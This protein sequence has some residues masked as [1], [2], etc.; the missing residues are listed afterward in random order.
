MTVSDTGF[1]GAPDAVARRHGLASLSTYDAAGVSLSTRRGARRRAAARP[2]SSRPA[3][4]GFGAFAGLHPLDDRR[5]L[6]ASTDSVG[7]KLMLARARGP[8]ARLR[9][10]PG[11]ALHQRRD[12][13]R[14]RAALPARLRRREADR[15]SSR[16]RELVEGAAEVCRAAGCALIGGETAE[17]PGIYRDDELD[18]AGT[19]VGIVERDGLVDG[20]RVEAGDV[21][22][23]F[24]SAGVHAN[25]FTLVR[26]VLEDEDYDGDRPARADA[27][28]PRRRARAA[29]TTAHALAHVTGGGIAGNLARV[30]PDGLRA[31]LDWDAWERPPVFEWLARA[32]RGGRAAP[33]L[34]PRDRLRAPSSPTRAARHRDRA[35]RRVIGV[36]VSGEGTN[37]Q[38]LIDAACRSRPSRRTAPA[39]GRSSAR[40]AAGIPTA[41]FALDDY[42]SREERD[43]AMA[44][45]LEAARRRARRVRGLHAPAHA[46]FLDRFPGRIVNIHPSLLPAF[47]GT[48]P[49]EDALAAGVPETGVTVHYVDEGVDTG[50]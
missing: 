40:A 39:R 9:R 5:L 33:R 26:R 11:R 48:R 8:P 44:D 36:L 47:P 25:G 3:R 34:Q 41:V 32:R 38:A 2:R 23:G 31:E 43:A 37:L 50:P 10:R 16:S 19:C 49:I 4:P 24:P 7:T 15:R 27:A 30:V 17:L 45:W 20:S 6:A 1:D 22:V 28:L 21:V 29:R 12:H 14:R 46:A 35:D 13:D 18:F 42:A